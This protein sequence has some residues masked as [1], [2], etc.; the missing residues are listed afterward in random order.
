MALFNLYKVGRYGLIHVTTNRFN[1]FIEA[2]KY[3]ANVFGY[4]RSKWNQL[5]SYKISGI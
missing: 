1:S 3:Y 5:F 4:E 2:E